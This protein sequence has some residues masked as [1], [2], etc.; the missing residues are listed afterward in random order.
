MSDIKQILLV[1]D[2]VKITQVLA[3]YL[4][5]SGYHT[6]IAHDGSEASRLLQSQ[7]FDL[8][9][10][11]LML[12]DISGETLCRT[13]RTHYRT[14][15]IML[16]AKSDEADVLTGLQIGADDYITKPFS[17]RI[18][19][20]KVEVVLRRTL[21]DHLVSAPVSYGGGFLQI[22][23]QNKT[24]KRQGKAIHLTPTEYQ[25]LS[26]MAKAPHRIFSR[27]QLISFALKDDYDGYDRSVDTYI[28]S[29][30]SKIEPDRRKPVFI[31]TVH[32]FGYQ[33]LGQKDLGER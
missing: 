24:V 10:L 26:M 25:I 7:P 32:G 18:V 2:E 8:I 17:P 23:F 4:G 31:T 15:V 5:K 9:L 29:I 21:S 22:D 12:P 11:D 13:I 27:D 30:R 14:P 16:T 6:A 28:K 33:F 3:A 20:A 1:D 19:V